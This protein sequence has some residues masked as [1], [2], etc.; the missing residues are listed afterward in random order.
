MYH[1]FKSASIKARYE[2][3]PLYMKEVFHF[4]IFVYIFLNSYSNLL[5]ENLVHACMYQVCLIRY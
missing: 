1:I 2:Y 5:P 4:R 3:K